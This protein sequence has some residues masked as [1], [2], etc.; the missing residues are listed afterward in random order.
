MTLTN[1]ATK[2]ATYSGTKAVGEP[3]LAA[4]PLPWVSREG[5]SGKPLATALSLLGTGEEGKNALVH[6]TE[7]RLR[8]EVEAALEELGQG[9]DGEDL[10]CPREDS[11]GGEERVL[12]G[13]EHRNR[14]P[15]A[16]ELLLGGRPGEVGVQPEVPEGG[17]ELP[18][19][20]AEGG[21]LGLREQ[22]HCHAPETRLGGT[23]A[24][25]E[26]GGADLDEYPQEGACGYAGW[27]DERR[28]TDALG[29]EPHGPDRYGRPV[30]E[31]HERRTLQAEAVEDVLRPEGMP[32]PL[33]R[34]AGLRTQARLPH[35]VGRVEAVALGQGQ[36][37]LEAGGVQGVAAREEDDRRGVLRAEGDNVRVAEARAD[38]QACVA[39]TQPGERLVVERPD[40]GLTLGR[41]VDGFGRGAPSTR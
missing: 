35:D 3:G 37:P 33:R 38:G 31:A 9:E 12:L 21:V 20:G 10:F 17:R 40:L 14:F 41:F 22:R 6:P 39:E 34:G 15:E 1:L 11:P 16:R 36:E 23:Q 7:R 26:C 5:Y 32:V 29:G 13:G 30:G 4:K 24:V 27:G 18:D 8:G 19:S 25:E 2:C 28:P